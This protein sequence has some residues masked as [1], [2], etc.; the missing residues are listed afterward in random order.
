MAGSVC[1]I[2]AGLS[3]LTC[4]MKLAKKGYNVTVI[5]EMTYAG[6][7]LATTRIGNESLELLP[8][9]LRKTD[10]NLLSLVKN[11]GLDSSVEWSDSR[12]HGK[13][14][15][16][17]VG[18][19]R[20]GFAR[21][22]NGLMQEITDNG[23]RIYLSTTA[24]DIT[25]I[26]RED[27][28]VAYKTECVLSNSSRYEEISD[29]VIF[30]GSC[31][32]FVNIS[33]NLPITIDDRD[34]L[35]NVTYRSQLTIMMNLKRVVSEVYYQDFEDQPF[36]RIVNHSNAFGQRNYGGNIVY[37]VGYTDVTDPLW[38][39][40]DSRIMDEYFGAF[41]KL[42]PGIRKSDIKSWR[43]TKTRYAQSEK[44][45]GTD[46]HNPCRNLYV[47]ASGIARYG[48][49]ETPLNRMDR[50]IELATRICNEIDQASA[51][52]NNVRSE[53]VTP[54]VSSMNYSEGESYEQR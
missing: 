17:K 26:R 30:T 48:T 47:C 42:Y 2:G 16:K 20:G 9:H 1:I 11:L 18:Y 44:Y 27:G 51:V 19:F 28:S 5:E 32:T 25:Q 39:A 43:L 13:A 3:G 35:M 4:A 10:K 38:I 33:H 54:L 49:A 23:G 50:L 36:A 37:L 45:P 41:R 40:S 31:R 22:I 24:S 6:G 34:Q 12:W 53:V 15:H 8:H 21:L 29:Y 7:L 14:A 52:T 46:L